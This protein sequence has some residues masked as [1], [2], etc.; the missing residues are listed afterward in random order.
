MKTRPAN[1]PSNPPQ[2]L[3]TSNQSIITPNRLSLILSALLYQQPSPRHQYLSLPWT[4]LPRLTRRLISPVLLFTKAHPRKRAQR[5]RRQQERHN[6]RTRPIRRRYRP[7]M[8]SKAIALASRI[9]IPL[10]GATG[11]IRHRRFGPLLIDQ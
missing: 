10:A 1:P 8:R 3:N 5:T 4:F 7:V 2:V 6:S 9:R 11:S